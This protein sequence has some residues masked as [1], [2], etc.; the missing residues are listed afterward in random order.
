MGTYE[1]YLFERVKLG[2][3]RLKPA[4]GGAAFETRDRPIRGG[5]YKQFKWQ[6][7]DG[8]QS[9]F[10]DEQCKYS[11]FTHCFACFVSHPD[12]VV[13]SVGEAL[14]F[15]VTSRIKAKTMVTE[16]SEDGRTMIH[17][18]CKAPPV[19]EDEAEEAR[20]KAVDKMAAGGAFEDPDE[21]ARLRKDFARQKK[22]RHEAVKK[23]ENGEKSEGEKKKSTEEVD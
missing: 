3:L 23:A 13:L 21:V 11:Q 9:L 19:P 6:Y 18:P 7:P 4:R 5:K 8:Y 10:H 14:Q 2:T 15:Y 22:E 17:R 20:Q 16:F 1:A 12:F